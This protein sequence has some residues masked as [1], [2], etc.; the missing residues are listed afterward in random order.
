MS[1]SWTVNAAVSG[2]SGPAEST[3]SANSLIE[4]TNA[5]WNPVIGCA[6]VS[7]GC[8]NCYAIV[9][10]HRLGHQTRPGNAYAG[11]TARQDAAPP[12]WTGLVR[13]LPER[14]ADPLDWPDARMVFVNSMSDL[15]H[16]NV[17]IEFIR[18]V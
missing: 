9:A 17:P 16:P 6:K 15:F 7:D 18:Q 14:L 5:T 8:R 12:N 13:C 10:A 11:L 2:G 3:M 4:W 1:I